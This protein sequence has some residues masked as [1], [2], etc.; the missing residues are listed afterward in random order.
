MR[1]LGKDNLEEILT[2]LTEHLPP[3]EETVWGKELIQIHHDKGKEE[4][5]EQ[6]LE[7]GR[8]QTLK[9]DIEK[10]RQLKAKGVLGDEAHRLLVES[11]EKEINEIVSR[12]ELTQKK[13]AAP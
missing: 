4:G 12:L 3:I 2:M 7:Q 9:A 1:S 11:A 10:Y 5:L 8:I 6:G 13:K